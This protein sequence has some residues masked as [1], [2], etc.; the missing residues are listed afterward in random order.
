MNITFK[1]L[2]E[3]IY[4]VLP[5]SGEAGVAPISVYDALNAAIDEL[6]AESGIKEL[7]PERTEYMG[8]DAN[9]QYDLSKL[10]YQ[11]K[12]TEYVRD[13][14]G[15]RCDR[16]SWEFV[17]TMASPGEKKYAQMNGT[18][19]VKPLVETF[20]RNTIAFHATTNTIKET[21][22]IGFSF[23]EKGFTVGQKFYVSGSGGGDVNP[24]ITENNNGI[25]TVSA[26]EAQTL[27]VEEDLRE[28]SAGADITMGS[29]YEIVYRHALPTFTSFSGTSIIDID[30][31][32]VP[33]IVHLTIA[34][35][36]Q[37]RGYGAESGIVERYFAIYEKDVEGLKNI[38]ERKKQK[39]L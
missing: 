27:T 14:V 36:A 12:R 7:M 30:E 13:P 26:V 20:T 35:M 15:N 33:A 6:S 21:S 18:I 16:K 32:F 39:Q 5:S 11:H 38:I 37:A 10:D 2:L 31:Y 28:E 17:K 3:E 25:F 29:V 1:E 9:N 8:I 23:I 24:T 19:L 34:N 22:T 4:Q